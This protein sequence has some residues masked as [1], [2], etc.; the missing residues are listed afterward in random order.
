MTH[1]IR[2]LGGHNK[3]GFH[4]GRLHAKNILAG[5]ADVTLNS[6]DGT[7]TITFAKPMRNANY[8]VLLSLQESTTNEDMT[9]CVSAK[10]PQDFVI[11]VTSTN[12]TGPVTIG[13]LVLDSRGSGAAAHRSSRFGSH[14]GYA[15]FRN[16]QWGMVRV[17]LNA[18][19]TIKLHHPMK[20]KPLVFA[21]IDDD[22]VATAG[23]IHV[24][25]GGEQTNSQFILDNGGVTGPSSTVDITWVAFDPGF[26]FGTIDAD[27]HSGTALA[28]EMNRQAKFGI[29]SGDFRAKNFV[30]GLHAM[31]TS[32][33]DASETVT[34]GQ[35]MRNVP[36]VFTML[37]SPVND[38]TAITYAG[39]ITDGDFVLGVEKSATANG[40]VYLGYLA[41][42][43]EWL[44][45]GE[46]ESEQ[47][48]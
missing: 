21:S 42:D 47:V 30:G 34:L 31:T 44:P 19:A 43:A 18:S 13:F 29:H 14:S 25:T 27:G 10:S 40:S 6:G 37:Q 3:T 28:G 4:S 35:K 23:F 17:A 32:S 22:T 39:T 2:V 12:H 1:S 15:H 11:N 41:I 38:T 7:E 33:N 24:A 36:I 20:N 46:P 48:A 16:L 26:N 8:L 9:L 45:T 5:R